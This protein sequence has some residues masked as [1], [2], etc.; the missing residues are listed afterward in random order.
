MND[1][2]LE[3]IIESIIECQRLYYDE[4]KILDKRVQSGLALLSLHKELAMFCTKYDFDEV[5]EYYIKEVEL[6]TEL[7]GEDSI[8]VAEGYINIG[9]MYFI[10]KKYDDAYDFYENADRISRKIYNDSKSLRTMDIIAKVR[11]LKGNI[12]AVGTDD[13]DL[14]IARDCYIDS[15]GIYTE[16]DEK[17]PT[18]LTVNNLILCCQ[19]LGELHVRRNIINVA[20]KYFLKGLEYA[21]RLED[22]EKIQIRPYA[23]CHECLGRIYMDNKAFD[24][25]REY[26]NKALEYSSLRYGR[27][28]NLY[29]ELDVAMCYRDLGD[30]SRK[31]QDMETAKSYYMES[32]KLI[33][34]AYRNNVRKQ[35]IDDQLIMTVK[36]LVEC[37]ND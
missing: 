5:R 1:I 6:Q 21:K 36:S 30:L 18:A 26:F 25:A 19:K 34:D 31:E 7:A 24:F 4:E 16:I 14:G 20:K 37:D 2:L 27:L 29:D 10:E 23:I 12:Y 13:D 33:Y 9:N 8:L 28:G 17:E 3:F 15:L 11:C 32:L 22:T 35:E